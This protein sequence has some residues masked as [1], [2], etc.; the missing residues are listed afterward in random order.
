MPKRTTAAK[1]DI[2]QVRPA[3]ALKMLAE[4]HRRVANLFE[5]CIAADA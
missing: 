2:T 3:D 4:D 1:K 5:Q